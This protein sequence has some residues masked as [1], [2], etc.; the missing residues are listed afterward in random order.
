MHE[1]I[2]LKLIVDVVF[3]RQSIGLISENNSG[4]GINCP[5]IFVEQIKSFLC[6]FFSA[7]FNN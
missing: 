6:L 5:L 2:K 3:V 4:A 7:Q 1:A